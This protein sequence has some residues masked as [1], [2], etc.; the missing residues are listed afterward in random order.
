MTLADIHPYL[1]EMDVHEAIV[2]A[3]HIM[4]LPPP[5]KR[6][7]GRTDPIRELIGT[8]IEGADALWK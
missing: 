5:P 2:C 7:K 6:P 1:G 8:S 4:S 3:E